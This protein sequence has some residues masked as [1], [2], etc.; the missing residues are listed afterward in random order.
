M[1]EKEIMYKK[2]LENH[3]DSFT[4]LSVVPGIEVNQGEKM[5]RIVSPGIPNWLSN[6]VLHCRLSEA[7]AD[8]VIDRTVEYFLARGVKPY[9]RIC[10]GDLPPDLGKR[11][12]NKG[13]ILASK[14]PAMAANLDR[15]TRENETK[16]GFTIERLI[17]LEEVRE[18]NGWIRSLGEGKTLG[19]LIL[20]LLGYYGF[21]PDSDWQHYI[22]LHHGEPVSWAS[23][24]YSSGAAGVYAVGTIPEARRQGFGS[25]LTLHALRNA[26]EKGYKIGVLQSSPMGY[27]LYKRL[28]FETCFMIRTYTLA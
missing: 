27:N 21:D 28:G 17:S 19:T 18:K 24:F 9:W 14:Q 13:F 15:L 8:E 12:E 1:S 5:T 10:P 3:L 23:I 16:D 20:K 26:R 25:A 7:E 6:A 2:S 22:G 4:C 11:L